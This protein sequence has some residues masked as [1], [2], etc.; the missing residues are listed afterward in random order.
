MSYL[1]NRDRAARVMG[2]L[3]K[4]REDYDAG[5]D[6][7]TCA[8]DLVADVLHAVNL[9]GGSAYLLL[10]RAEDNYCCEVDDDNPDGLRE[11]S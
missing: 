11:V 5:E 8:A 7:F 2:L 4:Y 3:D 1:S 6:L 9:T 10:E